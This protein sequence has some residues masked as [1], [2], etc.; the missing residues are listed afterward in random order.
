MHCAP[1]EF[2]KLSGRQE[3]FGRIIDI[4][5]GDSGRACIVNQLLTR[6]M[7]YRS[8]ELILDLSLGDPRLKLSRA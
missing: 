6:I 5:Q 3:R 4:A 1:L 7:D 8:S 2:G